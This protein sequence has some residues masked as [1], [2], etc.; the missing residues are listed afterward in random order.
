LRGDFLIDQFPHDIEANIGLNCE[1]LSAAQPS[2]GWTY[3]TCCRENLTI[4]FQHDER[5][6]LIG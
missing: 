6:I 4:S 3:R 2:I 5:D 1:R